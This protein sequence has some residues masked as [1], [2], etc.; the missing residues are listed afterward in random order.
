MKLFLPTQAR[1]RNGTFPQS[2]LDKT[3]PQDLYYRYE[4]GTVHNAQVGIDV[5]LHV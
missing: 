3:E 5:L 2:T 1:L 4:T